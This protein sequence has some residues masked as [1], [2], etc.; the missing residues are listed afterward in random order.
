MSVDLRQ[1]TALMLKARTPQAFATFLDDLSGALVEIVKAL[2]GVF[3]KFTG[4]GVLA[5][6]PT[7]YSGKDAGYYALQAA[8]ESHAA[9]NKLYKSSRSSFKSI[10]TKVGLGIGIDYGTV[11]LL[12]LADGLTV[13]GEPVV[14]ACRLAG[15]PGGST[16]LN[17]PAFEEIQRTASPAFLTSEVELDIKHEG[18]MLAYSVVAS[19]TRYDPA[20]A[21][22]RLVAREDVTAA[23]GASDGSDK[24][25][26]P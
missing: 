3:D 5:F 1:S 21:R 22:W 9:F 20:E 25:P 23:K 17:Q 15:A 26:S 10:L 12:Q 16:Y 13:V 18:P 19:G 2:E 14:Y 11:H 24:K 4:D 7:F 6:F 8:L